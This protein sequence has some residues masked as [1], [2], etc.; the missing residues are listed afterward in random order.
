MKKNEALNKILHVYSKYFEYEVSTSVIF[1]EV[2]SKAEQRDS[3]VTDI[4]EDLERELNK[5]KNPIIIIGDS[6]IG[7][8]ASE[9]LAKIANRTGGYAIGELPGIVTA[10]FDGIGSEELQGRI[11]MRAGDPIMHPSII[12]LKYQEPVP[13]PIIEERNQCNPDARKYKGKGKK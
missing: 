5:L 8:R 13:F 7:Y 10:K 6:H 3:A 2:D 11:I 9:E 4:I 12:E 1:D